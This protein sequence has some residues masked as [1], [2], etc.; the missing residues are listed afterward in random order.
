MA[1]DIVARL[2]NGEPVDI[3]TMVDILELWKTIP[4]VMHAC[5][6]NTKTR[7]G[8]RH[9]GEMKETMR[10]INKA[11]RDIIKERRGARARIDNLTYGFNTMT[12]YMNK[13]REAEGV[14]C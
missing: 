8:A 5:E 2:A 1:S 7:Q 6:T 13:W 9:V 3:A 4:A 12:R 14:Q 10:L 11:D